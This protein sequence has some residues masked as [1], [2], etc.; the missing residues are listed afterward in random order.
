MNPD[1]LELDLPFGEVPDLS[2]RERSPEEND[3]WQMENRR[4]RLSR[5]DRDSGF[6]PSGEP[7]TMEGWPLDREG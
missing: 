3:R 1:L 7:F 4:L 2:P 5:G 6:L